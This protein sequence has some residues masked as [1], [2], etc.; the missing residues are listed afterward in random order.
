MIQGIWHGSGTDGIVLLSED[1][2]VSESMNRIYKITLLVMTM[3]LCMG[4][5]AAQTPDE[6]LDE[7]TRIMST[8][9]TAELT[10]F[11][12]E[13][14]EISILG[15]RQAYSRAQA[16]YVVSQFLAEHPT[17]TFNVVTRGETNGTS[18][19]MVEYQGADDG[20]NVNIFIRI[21]SNLISEMQFE[22]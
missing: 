15:D 13:R 22:Q 6:V 2:K 16:Q 7:V 10:D 12:E 20:F 19:A 9:E 5:A 3:L 14:V 18:Y 11:F 1:H 8:P 17:S 21:S 4:A